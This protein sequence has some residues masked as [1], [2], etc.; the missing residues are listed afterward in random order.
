MKQLIAKQCKGQNPNERELFHETKGEAIDGILNDGFDDRYWG[1]NFGK[2]KWGHG[3]YFTDNPSVSHRYTEANPLDQTHIIYYN[4][5]VLGK[6]SILN[7]LNN[8]LISA[9]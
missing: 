4:K 3:A 5:V 7:E 2:G 1:P 8:E 6:E 9:R